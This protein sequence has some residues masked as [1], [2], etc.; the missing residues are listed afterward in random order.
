MMFPKIIDNRYLFIRPI[1]GGLSKNKKAIYKDKKT[2]DLVFCKF[3]QHD[4][5]LKREFDALVYL[6]KEIDG[7]T[8]N[9]RIVNV[10]KA[11]DLIAVNGGRAFIT[12][13]VEGKPL[14]DL[15]IS[16]QKEA[17]LQVLQFLSAVNPIKNAQRKSFLANKSPMYLIVTLPYFLIKNIWNYPGYFFL[18]INSYAKL[19][20]F[21]NIWLKLDPNIF[22]HGDING[23]NMLYDKKSVYLL[24]FPQGCMSHKYYDLSIA[25][26]SLWLQKGFQ[27]EL[28]NEAI[29]LFQLSV[30]E[31]K[32]LI[33]FIVYNLLQRLGKRYKTFKQEQFYLEKLQ[34]LIKT[35]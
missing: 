24:D 13:F 6:S 12:E 15:S 22:C 27:E 11:I 21:I 31:E 32:T 5:L 1:L 2:G 19:L 8:K 25:L 33:S 28:Y 14:L 4:S 30:S 23:S 18:F 17:Y 34:R 9:K 20:L 16:S 35:L 3:E 7:Q 29:K 10:P 26:N